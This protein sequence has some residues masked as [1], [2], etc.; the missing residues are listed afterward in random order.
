MN[1]CRLA[2]SLPS[3]L[4]CPRRAV[5]RGCRQQRG[6]RQEAGPGVPRGFRE[7]RPSPAP[8]AGAHE[9]GARSEPLTGS[10]IYL[11]AFL[12]SNLWSC[13][14]LTLNMGQQGFVIPDL[15]EDCAYMGLFAEL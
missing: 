14:L 15:V 13:H 7:R 9:A 3:P 4:H 1:E 12:H 5:F 2:L 11:K 8:A 6:A 10:E